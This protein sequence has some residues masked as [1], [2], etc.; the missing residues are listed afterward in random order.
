MEDI[1]V[2]ITMIHKVHLGL[3]GQS[4]NGHYYAYTILVR[5]H[6]WKQTSERVGM[7]CKDNTNTY[8]AGHYVNLNL[9]AKQL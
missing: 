3:M 2:C 9:L 7:K 5:K 4:N 8:T 6:L 1:T